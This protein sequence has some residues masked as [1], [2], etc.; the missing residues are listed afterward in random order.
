[1]PFIR[2]DI[3]VTYLET[4]NLK[5]AYLSKKMEDYF[6][7]SFKCK[8]NKY[9]IRYTTFG[10]EEGFKPGDNID[11]SFTV[12]T[13]TLLWDIAGDE[14]KIRAT[15][16]FNDSDV[17]YEFNGDRG[18]TCFIDGGSQMTKGYTY[19]MVNFF[20]KKN[21]GIVAQVIL[22]NDVKDVQSTNYAHDFHSFRFNNDNNVP[23]K[24]A[25]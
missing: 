4:D 14:D 7:K 5:P 22:F 15:Q 9:E 10:Y 18:I 6:D 24:P 25:K 17:K 1:M 19:A 23:H 3:D 12:F 13:Q 20:F 2:K 8:N 11:V 21:I 16:K